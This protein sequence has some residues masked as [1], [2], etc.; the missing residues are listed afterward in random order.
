VVPGRILG[1]SYRRE[2]GF[3]VIAV[4]RDVEG[5]SAVAEPATR[6]G[7]DLTDP[8]FHE[9]VAAAVDERGGRLDLLVHNA[10]VIVAGSV[11]ERAPEASRRE[12]MINLQAPIL[13]TEALH[14][15][16]RR[17]GGL[18]VGVG[19]AGAVF[20]MAESPGYSA[21]KAGLRSYLLALAVGA[22]RSGVR[23]AL[24]HPGSVDT[25]M[26]RREAEEGGSVLNF[27]SEPLSPGRVADAVVAN[28]DRVRLETFLPRSDRL[29]TLWGVVPSLIPRFQPL[30]ERF[31]RRGLERFRRRR[32]IAAEPGS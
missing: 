32:G 6:L 18:V 27:L 29:L 12:Q 23:I 9:A 15:A 28:L 8:D 21:S 22:R 10:G 25:P 11:G 1:D 3:H 30:L 26:L 14:P 31:G 5:L 17:A 7:L 4:D 13:L 20:P 16:L 2:R 19:S 24:V